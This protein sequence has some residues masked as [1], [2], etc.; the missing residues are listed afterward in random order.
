MSF[1]LHQVS[2]TD[3]YFNKLVLSYLNRIP[4]TSDLYAHYPDL[5]GFQNALQEIQRFKYDRSTLVQVLL[6]QASTVTNTSA[7]TIENIHLL[8]QPTTYT[9]TTGHQLCLFTGPAYFIY[10]IASIIQL[11]HELK[12]HFPYHQFVPVFWMNN[13]DHDIDEINHFTFNNRKYLWNKTTDGTP[14]FSLSTKGLE[15]LFEEMKTSNVFTEEILQLYETAYLKHSSYTQATRYLINEIFGKEGIILIEPNAKP[16]KEQ[17]KHHFYQDIINSLLY[18][19]IQPTIEK[20]NKTHYPVQVTPREINTFLFHNHK[21][22]LIK[23][24]EHSFHFK[25]T[26]IQ[27]SKATLE[28]HLEKHTEN[29]SPNV[30]LRPIYQQTILPNIAYVGGSAEVSYWL[31]L[32]EVFKAFQ[33]VYPVLIQ[34]PVLFILPENIQR[35][36]KKLNFN[37]DD[38]F[39]KEKH[40][41]IKE[42][43][44]KQQLSI[45]LE[46]Y[47]KQFTSVFQELMLLAEPIDKTLIAYI[48]AEQAKNSNFIEKLEQKLNRQIKQK[49]DILIKQLEDIYH[50]FFPNNNMQERVWN[51]FYIAKMLNTSIFDLIDE[52]LPYC[53]I[54]LTE[55]FKI[56]ILLSN[57]HER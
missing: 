23:K 43:L 21:R 25:D 2:H 41:L 36:M 42:I 12:R 55:H 10:K 31:E 47:Q 22:I 5:M 46:H 18:H 20:L 33:T 34:R 53:K 32:K 28:E 48:Q 57:E 39:T 11:S 44:D 50:T 51:I 6:Q 45:H 19:A 17:F 14:V 1:L 9:I 3:N 26:D 56:N 16:F 27:W 52:L 29:F 15:E 7:K 54:D 37:T 38:F 24:H 4:D 8:N 30:L 13:E 35:K 49:N 40:T